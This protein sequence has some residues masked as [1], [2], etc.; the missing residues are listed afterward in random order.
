[1]TT[2]SPGTTT[3]RRQVVRA[4]VD[5]ART[6]A[7]LV[8][9]GR[10][11]Q[12]RGMVGRRLRFQDGSEF[13][14]FRETAVVAPSNRE[15]ATLVVEFK[16]R[17]IGRNRLAHAIFRRECLLHTP[18]FAGFDGFRTK[19]WVADRT[20]GA[21]RGVYEWDGAERADRY[22]ISLSRLLSPLSVPG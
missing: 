14:V 3:G 10:L 11:I 21:Y 13:V 1:M 9:V 8:L 2:V 22:A 7:K 20:T 17:L 15:P 18:L 12:P 4:I 5:S 6:T 19:L 16:L